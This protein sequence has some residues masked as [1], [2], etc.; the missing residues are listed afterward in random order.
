MNRKRK[1]DRDKGIAGDVGDE[2]AGQI[3]ELASMDADVVESITE[4]SSLGLETPAPASGSD[5]PIIFM[6][7]L[8]PPSETLPTIM[9]E[10]S[11]ISEYSG[12]PPR[13]S[14]LLPY[15]SAIPDANVLVDTADP[16]EVDIETSS[17][18]S[19]TEEASADEP[20]PGNQEVS[21]HM[22]G[23]QDVPS[24]AWRNAMSP[25]SSTSGS[26]SS[27][28]SALSSS[29]PS[30]VTMEENTTSSPIASTLSAVV[31]STSSSTSTAHIQPQFQ[32][33]YY[34][35]P[36]FSVPY[37]PGQP[38]FLIPG[39]YSPMPY[40]LRP[41][42]TYGAPAPCPFQAYQYA[43]VP[44]PP[45]QLAPY[46][47]RPYPYSPWAPYANGSIEANWFDASAQ[48]HV[49]TQ[50]QTKPQRAKRGWGV[51]DQLAPGEGLRIV[52]VQPN[53]FNG[54]DTTSPASSITSAPASESGPTRTIAVPSMSCS[55]ISS[56]YRP[57]H[58]EESNAKRSATAADATSAV[59]GVF[60]ILFIATSDC[61][62]LLFQR[63]CSSE[64]C[65]RQILAEVQGAMCE[66]CKT[67]LK[68]RLEK[69]KRRLKLEP[70]KTR[71]QSRRL[72]D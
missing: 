34:M 64:S 70:R 43:P 58:A 22:H 51:A 2:V 27:S 3:V 65:R 68:R 21:V 36:P 7:P 19:I 17:Q 29:T 69:T 63:L 55:S 12:V 24:V 46:A 15:E 9:L 13:D 30:N 39:T 47:L 71:L 72:A 25:V 45:G 4:S 32:V 26:D 52:M 6:E 60:I 33:P 31:L 35:P 61:G 10:Q 42:Y 5:H 14:P 8:L 62:V 18:Q 40:P 1:S 48:A 38:P 44:P 66:R 49:Q 59:S 37:S 57:S 11:E 41:S 50:V 16:G 67:R 54:I 20:C 56:A 53:G 23:Q 28:N